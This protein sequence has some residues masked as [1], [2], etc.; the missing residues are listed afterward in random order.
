MNAI[1][2]LN[3]SIWYPSIGW[4]GSFNDINIWNSSPLHKLLLTDSFTTLDYI[5]KIGGEYFDK[6][7]FLADG[8]YPQLSRFVQGMTEPSSEGERRFTGWQ[9]SSRKD[10]ER[11]FGVLKGKSRV[12]ITSVLINFNVI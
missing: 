12:L 7:F 6:L 2:D 5:F 9:E 11:A 3:L 10:V 8:I 4:S 1:A